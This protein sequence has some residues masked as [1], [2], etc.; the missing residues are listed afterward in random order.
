M[1]N[2]MSGEWYIE[3]TDFITYERN[4]YEYEYLTYQ[5]MFYFAVYS[6]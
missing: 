3:T 4:G 2:F 6:I 1:R 5:R